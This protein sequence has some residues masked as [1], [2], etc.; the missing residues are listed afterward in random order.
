MKRKFGILHTMALGKKSGVGGV[1]KVIINSAESLGIKGDVEI[2]QHIDNEGIKKTADE[3]S[4][5]VKKI[6]FEIPTLNNDYGGTSLPKTVIR[7]LKIMLSIMK[8]K[9]L[10]RNIEYKLILGHDIT[11]LFFMHI[12]N[13]DYKIL[14]L[15]T[16]RFYESKT[17]QFLIKYWP[18]NKDLIYISPSTNIKRAIENT[19]P[20]CNSFLVHTPVFDKVNM[21]I[22]IS[23][24]TNKTKR[25]S[26][27]SMSLRLCYVGR[28]SPMK[29]MIDMV[30]FVD[31][32]NNLNIDAILDIY[33]E[34]FNSDQS[35]YRDLLIERI[36]SLKNYRKI[37]FRGLT[38]NPVETFGD[39]DFSIIF[40]DG[41]AIALAGLESFVAGTPVIGYDVGGI[42]ELVGI[43]KRGLL[44]EK[45]L[46]EEG[47]KNFK[48]YLNRF[49]GTET[50]KQMEE[51]VNLFT[52]DSFQKK[53]NSLVNKD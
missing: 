19:V 2:I 6:A 8:L 4:L 21:K 33:G 9:F 16:E 44:I 12:F 7:V 25:Y 14:M 17:A 31:E 42:N 43:E 28:F 47:A 30:K 39:Y 24:F 23:Q 49:N 48:K 15:H 36:A 29:N 18:L 32:L 50:Y 38:S 13:S 52:F 10:N 11:T 3:K 1:Q 34:P 37:N 26:S 20:D 27:S 41:E 40:S 53:V 22:D 5:K 46:V 35:K 45:G 51:F